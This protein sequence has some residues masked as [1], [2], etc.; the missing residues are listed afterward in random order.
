MNKNDLISAWHEIHAENRKGFEINLKEKD[1]V[2]HSRIIAKVLFDQKLKIILYSIFLAVYFCLMIYAFVYLKL[3]LSVF[4][5]IPLTLVGLF[6]FI[7]ITSEVSRFRILNETSDNMSIKESTILFRKKINR[8]GITDFVSHIIFFYSIAAGT[9]FVY[10]KDIGGIK[11][12]AKENEIS[13]LLIIYILFVLLIPWFLKYQ[14]NQNFKKLFSRLN[15]S[16]NFLED[17]S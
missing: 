17:E 1:S 8:I 4:S 6:V 14:H 10:I 15:D 16:V 9:V 13:A 11:N 12:L 5:I 3:N 2:K 7:K